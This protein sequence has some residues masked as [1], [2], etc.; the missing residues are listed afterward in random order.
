MTVL[1]SNPFRSG[2]G[3]RRANGYPSV[4][5]LPTVRL[6][7]AVR[8]APRRAWWRIRGHARLVA[9]VL[10]ALALA[11]AVVGPFPDSVT[12]GLVLLALLFAAG[13]VGASRHPRSARYWLRY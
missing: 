12:I 8:E 9:V 5:R 2:S 7:Q 13:A 3:T 10:S 4:G 1:R 6:V 11:L